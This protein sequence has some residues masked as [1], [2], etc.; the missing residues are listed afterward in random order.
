VKE[1]IF[2]L[3]SDIESIREDS[4]HGATYLTLKAADAFKRALECGADISSLREASVALADARPM[5]ASI[6]RFANDLLFFMDER[7]DPDEIRSFCDSFIAG[8]E[9]SAR[10]IRRIA[11]RKIAQMDIETVMTHSYSSLVKD[12][13]LDSASSRSQ[14]RVVCTESRPKNEGVELARTLCEAGVDTTLVTDASSP[15]LCRGVDMLLIGADG[16]GGFGLVHKAGTYPMVLAAR[17]SG[18]PVVVLA[19]SRKFWPYELRGVKEPPK[20]PDEIS[21]NGCF[22][23]LNYYFDTT[24]LEYIDSVVTE[25]GAV[26]PAEALD[27]CRDSSLHPSLSAE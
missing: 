24:P 9:E 15:F 27:M 18:V 6:F 4:V 19:G 26:T 1:S 3:R 14:V 22:E 20:S 12:T 21:D 16:I 13:L 17:E 7:E 25:R 11:V 8:L 2:R 23:V 5:M 10:D